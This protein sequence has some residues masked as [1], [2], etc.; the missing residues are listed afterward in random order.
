MPV[1]VGQALM[2]PLLVALATLGMLVPTA[3]MPCC[4]CCSSS[5]DQ[6]VAAQPEA[7]STCCSTQQACCQATPRSTGQ[8]CCTGKPGCGVPHCGCNILPAL[9]LPASPSPSIKKPSARDLHW[10]VPSTASALVLAAPAQPCIDGNLPPPTG[11]NLRL[12]S[13]L[14]IWLN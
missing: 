3:V 2:R 4:G 11:G 5:V 8:P 12:H 14:C 7:A 1:S 10:P 13:W 9:A 6:P